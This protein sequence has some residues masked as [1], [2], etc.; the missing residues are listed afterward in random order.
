MQNDPSKPNKIFLISKFIKKYIE[1]KNII[2]K[3]IFAVGVCLLKK[4]IANIMGKKNQYI[5]D[6]VFKAKI[7]NNRPII[8]SIVA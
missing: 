8:E 6:F 7:K 3:K 4:E 5:L 1:D 2:N